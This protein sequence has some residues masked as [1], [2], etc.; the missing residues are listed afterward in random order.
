MS[1]QTSL[2]LSIASLTI[3]I[4]TTTFP[5]HHRVLRWIRL[6]LAFPTALAAYAVT[7]PPSFR[8]PPW[9]PKAGIRIQLYVYG[10]SVLARL[11]DVCVI[12]FFDGYTEESCPRL[13]LRKEKGDD[14][15]DGTLEYMTIPLPTTFV[16]RL[17]YTWDSL[18]SLRGAS[19]FENCF[20]SWSP[21]SIREYRAPA[22]STFLRSALG[23]GVIIFMVFDVTEFILHSHTWNVTDSDSQVSSLPPLQQIWFALVLGYWTHYS[24]R[25]TM[26]LNAIVPIVL[27][28]LSPSSY[29]PLFLNPALS[30]SLAELWAVRWHTTW[31]RTFDRMS[32]PFVWMAHRMGLSRLTTRFLRTIIIFLFSALLHIGILHAS[33]PPP[34]AHHRAF[35]PGFVKFFMSQPLGLLLEAVLIQPLTETLPKRWKTTGRRAYVWVWMIWTGR[36]FADAWVLTGLYDERMLPFSPTALLVSH[37]PK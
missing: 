32:L 1:L 29:P 15:N 19:W 28:G 33:P 3:C 30:A 5:N 2:P 17:G 11:M 27:F 35:E 34:P 7:F 18:T 13:V 37:W 4:F 23:H 8:L 26:D 20:W 10:V 22:R 16:G 9:L 36:W 12:G 31:R 21:K 24:T 14:D 25:L 6:T